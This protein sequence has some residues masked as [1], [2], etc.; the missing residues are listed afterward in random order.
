MMKIETQ[1]I[2][3]GR[4]A[5]ARTGAIT[6]PLHLATTFERDADGSYP[7]EF[8]YTRWDNP[9]RQGLEQALAGLEGGA[10]AA[11]FASGLAAIMT[12][13]QALAAGDHVIA[14]RDLYHGTTKMLK[15]IFGPWNLSASYVD[16]TEPEQV[17]AALQPNTRLIF[18]ETPS[19]PTLRIT[20]L[21]AI[22]R[23]A[24]QAGVRTVVDNTWATPVLQRPLQLGADL[25]VHSTTKYMGGHS[26]VLGGAIIA[27][28]QDTFF[29]RIRLIQQIGGAVPAPFDC[30]L[31]HR[32][33]QT[34]PVRMALH[35]GQCSAAGPFP[36]RAP[37]GGEG[38]LSGIGKSSRPSGGGPANES[39]RRDD[40]LSGAGRQT[41]GIGADRGAEDHCPGHQFGWRGEFD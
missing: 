13:F 32:G 22:S 14:S 7:R 30:W 5:D 33:L 27:R 8:I 40:V 24:R 18:L 35:S 11:A 29:D 19:N 25:V 26:D 31:V 38:L 34:L 37:G 17:A 23:I 39:F 15:E 9:N 28:E 6:P 2:H 4:L 16:T 3:L 21:A 41:G 1:A 36:G 20:D 10:A 12:V